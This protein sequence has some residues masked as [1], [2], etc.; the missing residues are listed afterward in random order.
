MKLCFNPHTHAGC[1]FHPFCIVEPKKGF[2]PHTHAGCDNSLDGLGNYS[3]RFNPHTH[4]GCDIL[5]TALEIILN[6]SIHTPTQGV[7]LFIVYSG[8]WLY[9]SI[10]TPTQGVT[11]WIWLLFSLI[12]SFNPHTHAG[13]D[14]WLIFML[15][16]RSLFQSTHTHAGCDRN[17]RY[18]SMR[19]YVSIHTPTQGVTYFFNLNL[20]ACSFNPHTHAGCDTDYMT[21]AASSTSFQSTHPR[22]V[23][24][25]NCTWY[26]NYSG[27]QSTHPRRVWLDLLSEKEKR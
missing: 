24:R 9:V 16:A 1:D 12:R 22:R 17:W 14:L 26:K 8:F 6:V 21:S 5:S 11:I 25:G 7:T 19:F 27:F 10:H 23:W 20:T 15:K 3:E 4:A 13:C 2:N 18:Y